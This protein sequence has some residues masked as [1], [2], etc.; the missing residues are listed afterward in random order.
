MNIVFVCPKGDTMLILTE[1]PSVA[2]DFASALG[3]KFRAGFYYGEAAEITNCVGHLFRLQNP[4]FYDAKFK[5]W[6]EIP[7][8]PN[9]FEIGRAHV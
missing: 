4:E 6:S 1:K 5:S 8:I 7:I 9:E 3:C 2:R